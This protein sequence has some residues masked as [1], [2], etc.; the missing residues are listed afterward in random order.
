M[1]LCMSIIA[2]LTKSVVSIH[3][4]SIPFVL[5]QKPPST[6]KMH[7][8]I[9]LILEARIVPEADRI[10]QFCLIRDSWTQKRCPLKSRGAIWFKARLYIL[11][12]QCGKSNLYTGVQALSGEDCINACENACLQ[13]Y[14]LHR[15][16]EKGEVSEQVSSLLWIDSNATQ[17]RG[18]RQAQK[19]GI[20]A[21]CVTP[22]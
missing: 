12:F 4:H 15:A 18:G 13:F 19:Q 10:S 21:S 5:G 22:S 9:N 3:G 8:L 1:A 16:C 6:T 11:G 17:E 7:T 14:D 2:S 20:P